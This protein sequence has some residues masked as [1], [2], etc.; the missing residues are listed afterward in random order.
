MKD[1]GFINILHMNEG[2][3]L[4]K[5]LGYVTVSGKGLSGSTRAGIA[6]EPY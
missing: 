3:S 6:R 5:Q 4:W 2:I 1:M